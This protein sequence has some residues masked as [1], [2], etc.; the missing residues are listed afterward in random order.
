MSMES[1]LLKK[2]YTV[3]N[4][5][6]SAVSP[7]CSVKTNTD[8][9][10]LS[11]TALDLVNTNLGLAYTQQEKAASYTE[12]NQTTLEAIDAG[13]KAVQ[14]RSIDQ[15]TVGT[16]NRVSAKDFYTDIAEGN[17]TGH[18]VWSK[19]GYN[20][21][22][23]NVEEDMMPL[24]GL[25]T[26]PAA[27]TKMD[28]ASNDDN[29]GKTGSPTSTGART[30]KIYGLLADFSEDSETITMNGTTPVTTTKTY[31]RINNM[32]IATA[33][34]GVAIGNLS[35]SEVGG[36][37]YKYGYI[38]AGYTRQRQFIYTVPLGKTL[39]I[40]SMI[41]CGVN[42]AA[43]HW[44]RFTLRANYDEKSGLVLATNMFM[45]F[46]EIQGVDVTFL[47]D[48][49]L[50]IKFPATVSLR[51]NVISDASNAD[52]RCSCEARGYLK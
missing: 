19:I 24:G 7:I 33:G 26:F 30:V 34:T 18:S 10:A 37:T 29:D 47:R 23:D 14:S 46:E 32:R 51:M 45:P 50:P 6:Q 1:D 12:S 20:D 41:I 36:T 42:A 52:E 49:K 43:N 3:L 11:N 15:T 38:R 2:L 25:Y 40:T 22:V 17:L 35:L 5:I 16:T 13:I 31:L 28:L 44:V 39:Y 21:N 8:N 9:I 27:A 48:Y 4:S